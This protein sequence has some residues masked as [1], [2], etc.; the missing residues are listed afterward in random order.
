[1]DINVQ[2]WSASWIKAANF[3]THILAK[4]SPDEPCNIPPMIQVWTHSYSSD[5]ACVVEISSVIGG[6]SF[7]TKRGSWG[8]SEPN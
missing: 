2:F 8:E 4:E 7:L 5:I 6:W 1:M 3:E